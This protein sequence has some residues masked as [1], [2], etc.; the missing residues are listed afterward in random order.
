M[1]ILQQNSSKKKQVKESLSHATADTTIYVNLQ[2]D[3]AK[4]S[5][6]QNWFDK[7]G[8]QNSRCT[9]V[10]I[11]ED[12]YESSLLGAGLWPIFSSSATN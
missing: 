4:V 7:S 1:Y 5:L 9:G 2:Y 12:I 8:L 6:R 3:N 11:D 10:D